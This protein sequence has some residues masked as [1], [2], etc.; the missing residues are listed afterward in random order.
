MERLR[1]VYA[2]VAVM[3]VGGLAYVALDVSRSSPVTEPEG[4]VLGNPAGMLDRLEFV[5]TATS[6]AAGKLE[7]V[8]VKEQTPAR[9]VLK[10]GRGQFPREGS[11]VGPEVT[12]AMGF[13]ELLPSWNPDCPEGT[14]VRLDVR[15]R[16]AGGGRWSPW[17]YLGSWGKTVGKEKRVTQDESFGGIVRIDYLKLRRTADAYQ[18]RITFYSFAL[19]EGVNPSVR[20]LAVCYSGVVEEEVKRAGGMEGSEQRTF[21]LAVPFR[22]Q[23][24]EHKALKGEICSPTSVSMVMQYWGFDRP[25]AEN[26]LAIY[27]AEYD[28]FGNWGRAVAWAG[29][30]GFDAY[31]R[32]YRN[33]EQV[34][35]SLGAGQPIVASVRFKEGECPSFVMKKT[36]GHLIVIRGTTADGQ[37]IVNDPASKEKGNG[38]IYK[39]EDVKRAWLDKGG[40]GYV[41]RRGGR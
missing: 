10:D 35:E 28:L 36:A 37:V 25:T 17:F 34:K 29:Q 20:R 12:S 30:N 31:L 5:D 32:R 24:V 15:V 33:F 2:A 21:D 40:V 26:A 1:I 38:A 27:D 16:D 9:V 7:R 11:W 8:E 3:L 41:I 19:D 22:A 14:G 39:A 6:W 4:N 23:T 13:T 18:A